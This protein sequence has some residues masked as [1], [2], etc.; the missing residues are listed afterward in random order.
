[1]TKDE[2]I[3][4]LEE[5]VGAYL[6]SGRADDTT[7]GEWR[8]ILETL[9]KESCKVTEYDRN[10]IYY[11]GLQY[12]SLSRFIEIAREQKPCKDAISKKAVLELINNYG[13]SMEG[14]KTYESVCNGLVRATK[15]ALCDA[16]K[17]LPSVTPTNEP[18]WIPISEGEPEEH[19]EY[20]ITWTTPAFDHSLIAI[21]EGEVTWEWDDEKNRWKFEWLLEDYIK[22]YPDVKVTAWMPLIEAY[23]EGPK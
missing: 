13:V 7:C 20:Y 8:E 16:I 9:R 12:I 19:G 3:K 22:A 1:M 10:H 6:L 17:K 5:T 11:K 21:C 14:N 4:K 18:K 15:I 2:A 23:K